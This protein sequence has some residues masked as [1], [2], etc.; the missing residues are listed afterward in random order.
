MT[1]KK[2]VEKEA[3]EQWVTLCIDNDIYGIEVSQ[4]QEVL[5]VPTITPVPGSPDY[6]IGIVNLRGNIVTVLN[7]RKRF[8]LV[9]ESYNEDSQIIIL[10]I[11]EQAIGILVDSV[12][13][14][15]ELPVDRIEQAPET[16]AN[17][18]NDHIRGVYSSEGTLIILINTQS[19]VDE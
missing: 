16:G 18:S 19:L 14:V 4:V 8:R 2:L 1:T 15:I 5:N 3:M 9:P 11:D 13:E 6:V 7:A 17:G 10:R 12:S